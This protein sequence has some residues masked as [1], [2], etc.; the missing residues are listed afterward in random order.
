MTAKDWVDPA[1]SVALF[2][3]GATD[4]D[5]GADGCRSRCPP[6]SGRVGGASCATPSTTAHTDAVGRELAVSPR[7]LVVLQT[8]T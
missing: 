6:I 5:I 8:Q 3:D 7:S 4:P 1:R 2:I